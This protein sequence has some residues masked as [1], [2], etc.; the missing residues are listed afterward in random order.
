[1]LETYLC[2]LSYFSFSIIHC[3]PLSPQKEYFF[4]HDLFSK[5]IFSVILLKSRILLFQIDNN[6]YLFWNTGSTKTATIR[7]AATE[8]IKLISTAFDKIAATASATKQDL[9]SILPDT[10][11]K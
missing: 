10:N 1:M 6:I 8:S 7:I 2:S 3:A 9:Y 11:G 4:G 5:R